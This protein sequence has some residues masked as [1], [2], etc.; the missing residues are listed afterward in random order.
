MSEPMLQGERSRM[1]GLRVS[2]RFLLAPALGYLLL[3]NIL[4]LLGWVRLEAAL[5]FSLILLMAGVFIWRKAPVR[6]FTLTGRE[7]VFWALVA[8]LCLIW[9]E[10]TGLNGHVVQHDDF[11]VRHAIYDSLVRCDWPLY[12]ARGEYFS[13]YMAFWL[14]PALCAR[15]C[16]DW[17][18]RNV[19]LW[20]WMYAGVLLSFLALMRRGGVRVLVFLLLLMALGDVSDW[21]D[22]WLCPLVQR[23]VDVPGRPGEM[24]RCFLDLWPYVD[25]PYCMSWTQL[26]NL[27]NHIIP[28]WVF[29]GVVMG[30]LI[31]PRHWLFA[32]ALVVLCSPLAALA[33][34]PLLG[35]LLWPEIRRHGVR[36]IL[37]VP[38]LLAGAYLIFPALYLGC[39]EGSRCFFTPLGLES[40]FL[41][42][43]SPFAW[44]MMILSA[45]VTILVPAF[46]FLRRYRA[47]ALF[48]TSCL[49]A[50]LLPFIYVGTRHN[51]LCMKGSGVMWYCLAWMYA[52]CVFHVTR[53]LRRWLGL[54]LFLSA[55]MALLCV[56]ALLV[57]NYSWDPAVMQQHQRTR[58]Q[59][60]LNHPEDPMYP[61]FWGHQPAPLLFYSRPGESSFPPGKGE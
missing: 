55:P 5:P 1:G 11:V 4:F 50:V 30:R 54:Y 14:P 33:L 44:L 45:L 35:Y 53:R 17:V 16:G 12:S 29:L 26:R 39:N 38:T 59:G 24:A 19:I 40:T 57:K 6:S 36:V 7:L 34:L 37:N 58:W 18:D 15:L 3:P 9:V 13:Y 48:R 49:L 22:F 27:F 25:F 10:S 20:L 52:S 41:K 28:V 2:S 56:T 42:R 8:L 51:E 21:Y 43:L 32:S 60:H 31:Q 61:S 46:I 47:T 23:W